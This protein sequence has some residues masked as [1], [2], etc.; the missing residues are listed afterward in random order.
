MA[1][2]QESR[3]TPDISVQR[4]DEGRDAQATGWVG[5]VT[6]GGLMM[7]LVGFFGAI[8]GLTALFRDQY[9][10]VAKSGLLVTASYT[11]WGWVHLVLGLLVVSVG[12]GVLVGQTWA[13]FVGIFLVVVHALVN[14]AFLAAFPAWSVIAIALD[15]LV[16]Y[17]LA[18]HGREAAA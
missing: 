14:L 9:F 3:A 10:V 13:R 1:H 17:A 12:C 16:I 8:D 11:T 15:V 4:P 6:F 18:V 2:T 7:V 5:W